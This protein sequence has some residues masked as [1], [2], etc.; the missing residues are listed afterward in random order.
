M[1]E[2]KESAGG[3]RLIR[4]RRG[5]KAKVI[6]GDCE[7]ETERCRAGRWQAPCLVHKDI[8]SYYTAPIECDKGLEARDVIPWLGVF[9]FKA[10][11]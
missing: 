3:I 4:L 9:Q 5:T 8:Y 10:L 6:A 7:W 11:K 1:R 2:G